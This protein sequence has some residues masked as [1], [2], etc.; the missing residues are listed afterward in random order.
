[1][2]AFAGRVEHD[3]GLVQSVDVVVVTADPDRVR[4]HG[5]WPHVAV[6]RRQPVNVD[7]TISAASCYVASVETIPR[8]GRTRRRES[9][10]TS[11]APGRIDLGQGKERTIAGIISAMTSF[12][13]APLV[14]DRD[15]DSP[16]FGY[17]ST[18]ASSMG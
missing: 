3:L 16:F 18:V 7:G 14:D 17:F 4:G 13:R 1:M 10:P 15:G 9:V 12:S 5:S 8:R 2:L 6:A 11:A